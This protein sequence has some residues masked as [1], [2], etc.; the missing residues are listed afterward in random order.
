MFRNGKRSRCT[1]Q[2]RVVAA[3]RRIPPKRGTGSSMRREEGRAVR[4]PPGVSVRPRETGTA[5]SHRRK[6]SARRMPPW[7]SLPKARGRAPWRQATRSSIFLQDGWQ[8]SI[9]RLR[10]GCRI[11][12]RRRQRRSRQQRRCLFRLAAAAPTRPRPRRRQQAPKRR[13]PVWSPAPAPARRG[14]PLVMK[15]EREDAM[16]PAQP[17]RWS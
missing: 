3:A 12:A 13:C 1:V 17:R 4:R 6:V 9:R 16:L 7:E 14:Q 2:S 11:A 5:R 10:A 8:R 15:E